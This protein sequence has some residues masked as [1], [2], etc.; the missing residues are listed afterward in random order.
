MLIII[1]FHIQAYYISST[2]PFSEQQ[3][4][5]QNRQAATSTVVVVIRFLRSSVSS[6]YRFAFLN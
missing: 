5:K 2:I 3:F 1:K 6:Q 4:D